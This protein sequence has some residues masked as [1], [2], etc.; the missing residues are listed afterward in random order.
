MISFMNSGSSAQ[1]T[2]GKTEC[3]GGSSSQ[4]VS[5]S[6]WRFNFSNNCNHHTMRSALTRFPVQALDVSSL[7]PPRSCD[8]TGT[9]LRMALFK[10]C[11]RLF[12]SKEL[13]NN[14]TSQKMH[15]VSSEL[16]L[17]VCTA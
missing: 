7:E 9:R 8:S 2:R 14:Y 16:L 4:V 15:A 10:I 6:C 3:G 11:M 12:A 17:T 1:T 13:F 5:P